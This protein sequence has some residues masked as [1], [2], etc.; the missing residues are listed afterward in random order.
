MVFPRFWGAEAGPS[1]PVL[2]KEDGDYLL[3][4]TGDFTL[5]EQELVDIST[6]RIT[7]GRHLQDML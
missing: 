7:D 5:L 2:L 1:A 3:L 6:R 4:E